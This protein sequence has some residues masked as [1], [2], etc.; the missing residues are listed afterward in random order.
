[1][2]YVLFFTACI[3]LTLS[4]A[5]AEDPRNNWPHWRG[6]NGNG[7]AP[8]ADPPLKWDEKTNIKWKAPLT[9]KGSATPIVWGDQIFVLTAADTGRKAK[10]ADLP[11]PDPRFETKTNPPDTYYRFEVISFDRNTGKPRWQKTAAEAVPHEGHHPTHSYCA[12][13]PTTDGKFLYVSFGSFGI[14]CYDLDGNLKWKRD[15]GRIHS[16]SA[17]AKLSR[18]SF[19][20]TTCS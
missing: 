3:I 17:G 20:A 1:M 14:Y 15:L 7:V 6:P 13:S 16:R 4:T 9:G 8:T 19:M 18:R 5:R 11:K 2:R 10:P 12:G